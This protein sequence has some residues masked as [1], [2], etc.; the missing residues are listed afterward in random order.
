[1]ELC[2]LLME[3]TIKENGTKDWGTEKEECNK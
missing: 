3:I 1:M 2:V